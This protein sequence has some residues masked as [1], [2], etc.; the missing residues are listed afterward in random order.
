MILPM[1][2]LC[3]PEILVREF[4]RVRDLPYRIALA[5]TDPDLACVGK[6][7]QFKRF[8]E[9]NQI[10]VRWRV[11]RFHWSDLPL[12]EAVRAF[13]HENEA[14]HAYLELFFGDAWHALDL[15]WD[16]WLASVFPIATWDGLSSTILAVPAR[17]VLS[18]EESFPL[19]EPE[20]EAKTRAE[21]LAKNGEFLRALN[22]WLAE[23]RSYAMRYPQ[24][25]IGCMVIKEGKVL[26]GKRKSRHGN[27]EYAWPGGHMNYLESLEGC[28]R[29]EVLEEAGI[30]VENVRLLRILNLKDYA[31]KH[32]VDFC[33]VADWKAGEPRICE[34][35]KVEQWGWYELDALPTPLFAGEVSAIEAYR[36]GKLLFDA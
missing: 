22:Q 23:V 18:P 4:R 30:E 1:S 36:T 3:T 10:S 14:T 28:A 19:V 13:P 9:V 32:Y 21:D 17:E 24:V 25:G 15:T 34:P 31:P 2:I 29:R 12:P 33:F 6:H 20:H 35:D 8:L 11:C 16:E 27:G 7:A 26:L 5:P